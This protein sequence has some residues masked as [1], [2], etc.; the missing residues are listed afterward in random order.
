MWLNIDGIW[1]ITSVDM[2]LP[3][4]NEKEGPCFARHKK[5]DLW[6]PLVEK[7]LAKVYGSYSNLEH[8]SYEDIIHNFTGAPIHTISSKEKE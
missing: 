1:Q 8:I 2:Y 6:L 4:F 5:G 7:C 3:C